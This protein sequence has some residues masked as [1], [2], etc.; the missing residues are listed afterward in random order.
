MIRF[1]YPV[2]L[3][4]LPLL[5][6]V[7]AGEPAGQNATYYV[8]PNGNDA[9]SGRLPEANADRTD[10]P[11]AHIG[12]ARDALRKLTPPAAG[13][14]V[15]AIRGGVYP[16]AETLLFGRGDSG[17]PKSHI[18]YRSY[19]DQPVRLMAA[20]AVEPKAFQV[21]SDPV[22]SARLDPTVRGKVM[23]LDLARLGLRH[24]G[25]F[26][27]VFQ[28][29]GGILN[30]Y[31]NDVR[32]PL[33][34]WPQEG[35]TTM[36]RVLD[37]GD[38][39]KGPSRHGGTF[40]YRGDRPEQWSIDAGVWLNGFWRV[41][42]TPE[43]VRV[44]SLDRKAHSITFAEPVN[45]GIG[46]KYAGQG[47]SGK[48]NWIA[49]NV[50]EE[51]MQPGQWCLDFRTK[52]LYFWP[53]AKIGP[54]S[55]RIADMDQPL[56]K[57]Q[58]ASYLTF[59]GIS[60][61]GGLGNGI[62]I[63]GG[64]DNLVAACTMRNLGRTGAILK[65]GRHNGVTGCDL[66]DLG[67]GGISISGGDRKTLVPGEH[68]ATN[69]HIHHIGQIKK[70]YAPAIAMGAY[71]AGAAVGNLASHNLIHDL[72]HAAVLYGGNDN[73][74][75]FNEIYR[76]ALDSG[77][78][79]AFYTWH[80]WTSRGNIVRY[81]YVHHSPAAN[82]FYMDDGDSGDT[83]FGNVVYQLSC[84]PFIG[85]GHDNIVRNNLVVD[86]SRAI[87]IDA[88]GA[89]R[90]YN[91]ANK[92]MVA[93]LTSVDYKNPPW[94]RRYPEMVKILESHPELPTSN[95]IENN[96]MVN[97]KTPMRL[98][99]KPAELQYS[100]IRSN[101]ALSA[102]DAGPI[103]PEKLGFGWKSDSAVYKKLPEFQPIPWEKI[104]LERDRYRRH[105]PDRNVGG[106]STRTPREI[107]DSNTDVK[108]SNEQSPR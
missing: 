25:P 18:V 92:Q 80:D 105:L 35:Y 85:G 61:E 104:G 57:L 16:M 28:D 58:D 73:V 100:M 10:G 79:G 3:L 65:G 99:G 77:D 48:E 52:T 63:D 44:K 98:G 8:A 38:W 11:F 1:L 29:G 106:D 88:R 49:I 36:A 22:V 103:D 97:C 17:T 87:H 23:Q 41:P 31:F 64:Q 37:R 84:G 101:V 4:V 47:G 75:E 55:V 54:T 34:R 5:G 102:A 21:V 60:F 94:S 86:C 96:L 14:R 15:V 68:F 93:A 40:V 78:V 50:L 53:P 72:P 81:N 7:V 89:A 13:D 67:H 90:N 51:L 76:V 42:W 74:F 45:A 43:T 33:A 12:R 19:G 91:A 27:D 20:G 95:V 24:V 108:R 69:N 107:F 56:V 59:E 32:M 39:S 83:I 70:T 2:V 6:D 9:W 71:D 30:L 46:S 62:E 26:P 66:F 82:A